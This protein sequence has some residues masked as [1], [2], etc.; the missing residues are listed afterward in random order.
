MQGMCHFLFRFDV[1]SG[2]RLSQRKA[3]D[4]VRVRINPQHE[5]SF[6][7]ASSTC[8]SPH[9]LGQFVTF[10]VKSKILRVT[11][12]ARLNGNAGQVYLTAPSFLYKNERLI[13][14]LTVR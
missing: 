11:L 12:S 9:K 10:N 8:L 7:I 6:L 1:E 14:I 4:I 13:E 3:F 2:G 5:A